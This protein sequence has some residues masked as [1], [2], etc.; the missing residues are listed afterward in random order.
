M[1][2]AFLWS[3]INGNQVS[4]ANGG[5]LLGPVELAKVLNHLYR[6]RRSLISRYAA[7]EDDIAF[8]GYVLKCS[9]QFK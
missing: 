3:E 1:A 9:L 4:A 5:L 2:L 6:F 8:V 7:K